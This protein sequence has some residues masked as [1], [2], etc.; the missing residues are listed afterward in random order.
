ME[1][2]TF[3]KIEFMKEC[4]LC[5]YEVVYEVALQYIELYCKSVMKHFNIF[6]CHPTNDYIDFL[7]NIF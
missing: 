2:P 4:F 1:T 3:K 5:S 6:I 7:I